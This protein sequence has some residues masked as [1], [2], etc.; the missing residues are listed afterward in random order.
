MYLLNGLLGKVSMSKQELMN[1]LIGY[2]VK[3]VADRLDTYV[4]MLSRQTGELILTY[5][6]TITTEV[7]LVINQISA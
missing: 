1:L 5:K 3:M 6:T 2:L 4:F 7:A